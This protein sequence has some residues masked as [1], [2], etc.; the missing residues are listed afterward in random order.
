MRK[1]LLFFVLFLLACAP[2]QLVTPPTFVIKPVEKEL[3]VSTAKFIGEFKVSFYWIVKEEDYSG[4][5]TTPLYLNDGKL[6]GYFPYKFVRD[7]K[8]ESCAQLKDGRLIS[9]LKNQGR[10]KIVDKFLGHGHFLIPLKSLATDPTVIPLGTR[11][12]LPSACKVKM[13]EKFHSG[14]FYTHDIGSEIIGKKIDIFLGEKENIRY[15]S[16]TNI[17]SG[18]KVDVY[19]LE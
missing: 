2:L 5:R 16:S 1:F 14:I 4:K 7:F 3:P 17:K 12:F 11:V 9:W 15:F 18:Q 10:A 6:L 13:G 19:L 8:I